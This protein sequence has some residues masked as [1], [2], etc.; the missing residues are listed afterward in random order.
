M[1]I[2]KIARR[3]RNIEDSVRKIS[4]EIGFVKRYLLASVVLVP[5]P[6]EEPS[7]ESAGKG[8]RKIRIQ[9]DD[10]QIGTLLQKYGLRLSEVRAAMVAE[11]WNTAAQIT[12]R[13]RVL[14]SEVMPLIEDILESKKSH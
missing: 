7:A 3:I 14:R 6:E 9:N 10:V 13:S 1:I 4:E 2:R 11:G 12:Y 8:V 5:K